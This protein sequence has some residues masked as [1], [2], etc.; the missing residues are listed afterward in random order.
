MM[1]HMVMVVNLLCIVDIMLLSLFLR[2]LL[3]LN[4]FVGSHVVVV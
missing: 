4:H 1:M 2:I 3:L